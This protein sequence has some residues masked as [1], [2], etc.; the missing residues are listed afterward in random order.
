MPR[1]RIVH[2]TSTGDPHFISA[3]G[4]STFAIMFTSPRRWN[5]LTTPR[6]LLPA[7]RSA[8]PGARVQATGLNQVANGSSS[9]DPRVLAETL[10]GAAGSLAV[11]AFVFA[12]LLAFLPL[13]IAA[14]SILT[15]LLVVLGITTFAS[16]SFIVLFSSRSSGL[17]WQS[18][19]RCWSSPAGARSAP[20][21]SVTTTHSWPLMARGADL[22][23]TVAIGLLSLIVLPVPGLQSR[24]RPRLAHIARG[25]V[26]LARDRPAAQ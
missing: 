20:T 9:K 21:A 26:W 16:V 10:I 11:R 7:A 8:L 24:R 15:T 6:A 1:S 22:G 13:L 23:L 3:D 18:T 12:S 4:R 5:A 19:T 25:L 14:V 17:G 2:L